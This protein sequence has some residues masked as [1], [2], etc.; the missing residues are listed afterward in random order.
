MVEALLMAERLSRGRTK[1]VLSQAVHPEYR[2]AVRT[3]FAN[4]VLEVV[5]VPIGPDGATDARA[6]AAAVDDKTFAVAV[7][8]PNFYGV[9]EDWA[10][11]SAAARELLDR[12][13][14]LPA[15]LLAR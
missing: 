12:S 2:E 1:A 14:A 10:V 3:Y 13:G 7:Q 11:A 5:D 6:L 9:V 15:R 8:S 4:L